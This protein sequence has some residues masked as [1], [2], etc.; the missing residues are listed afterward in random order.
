MPYMKNQQIWRCPSYKGGKLGSWCPDRAV[1]PDLYCSYTIAS[2]DNRSLGR[3]YRYGGQ[4]SLGE[5]EYPSSAILMGC[6]R[7]HSGMTLG[8]IQ[9]KD[10][11]GNYT[12][13]RHNG[14]TNFVFGDGHVKW[15]SMSAVKQSDMYF[16]VP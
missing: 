8:T 14:G 13:A 2:Y 11:S 3:A 7:G 4:L 1:Y 10:T 15:M 6:I 9:T 16:D 12:Y 5:V